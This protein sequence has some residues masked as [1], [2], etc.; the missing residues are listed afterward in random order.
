MSK[1]RHVAKQIDTLVHALSGVKFPDLHCN[2]LA[3][4]DEKAESSVLLRDED[5]T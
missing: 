3:V 4:D 2:E 1:N 5:N